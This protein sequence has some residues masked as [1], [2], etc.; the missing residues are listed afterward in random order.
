MREGWGK[1]IMHEAKKTVVGAGLV[2]AL[3]ADNSAEAGHNK[4][5]TPDRPSIEASKKSSTPERREKK[6]DY[7]FDPEIYRKE[8]YALAEIQYPNEQERAKFL[9][10][11][12]E[13]FK[14][15]GEK[16]YNLRIGNKNQEDVYFSKMWEQRVRLF[17]ALKKAEEKYGVPKGVLFA[18]VAGE[19]ALLDNVYERK[20][21]HS[22]SGPLRFVAITARNFGLTVNERVDERHSLDKS[23]EAAA[24]YLR[25]LHESFG[26]QWGLAAVAYGRGGP[27]ARKE[28]EQDFKIEARWDKEKKKYIFDSRLLNEKQVNIKTLHDRWRNG[29][30]FARGPFYRTELARVGSKVFERKLTSKKITKK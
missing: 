20:G 13:T 6:S 5:K 17:R 2:L 15:R 7:D 27:A 21:V 28:I 24:K 12:E 11:A 26:G 14:K 19:G 30:N 9:A 22:A 1:H 29:K 18:V 23:I 4:N 10:Q 3:G 16:I 8:L 25:G